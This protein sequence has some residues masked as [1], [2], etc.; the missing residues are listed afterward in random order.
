MDEVAHHDL[1]K[2][3]PAR[4]FGDD[5]PGVANRPR[6]CQSIE[7]RSCQSGVEP[8]EPRLE[9]LEELTCGIER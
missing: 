1:A 2:H 7:V 6:L 9:G 8:F 4:L 3:H 5:A